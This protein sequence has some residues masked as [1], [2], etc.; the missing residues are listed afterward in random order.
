MWTHNV[1]C[2]FSS[3]ICLLDDLTLFFIKKITTIVVDPILLFLMHHR[4]FSNGISTITIQ[5][6]AQNDDQNLKKK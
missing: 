1:L 3:T 5:P 4:A 2:D 6:D